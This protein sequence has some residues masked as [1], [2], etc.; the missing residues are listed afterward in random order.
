MKPAKQKLLDRLLADS[1]LTDPRWVAYIMATVKHETNH[2]FEP[3]REAY[4]LSED[5]RRDNLRYWPWYGR[6]YVQI[7]WEFNYLKADDEI[8]R[9]YRE[10]GKLANIDLETN[11]ELAMDPD[12][13]YEILVQGMTEGWFTKRKLVDYIN[14]DL[15]QYEQARRIVNGMDR[16]GLIAGYAR[17][18]EAQIRE[19]RQKRQ[20]PIHD[21]SVRWSSP[22]DPNIIVRNADADIWAGVTQPS[23]SICLRTTLACNAPSTKDPCVK[24]LQRALNKWFNP[25]GTNDPALDDDG[26]FGG[27]TRRGVR[28]FQRAKGLYD[29][30]IVGK[31]TWRA[32]E[33][34]L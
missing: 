15:C 29:D 22:F 32:L 31:N 18:Y 28:A 20:E 33:P 27:A 13:A 19:L 16:A 25:D 9:T 7:T 30:G 24:V 1:R 2:T 10:I 8:E 23:K 5:W 4:W 34:Y 17:D 11:P 21:Q 3:V 12:I 6:G 14:G 26:L